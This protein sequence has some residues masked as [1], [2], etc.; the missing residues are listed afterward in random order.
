MIVTE[1]MAYHE[2]LWD[3]D[4]STKHVVRRTI[5]E[6]L[7]RT[8]LGGRGMAARLLAQEVG[9]GTAEDVLI[10]SSGTLTGTNAPMSGRCTF[11]FV[12]PATQ[13]YFKTSAGGQLGLY[14][15]L[16][17]VDYLLIRGIADAPLYIWVDQNGPQLRSAEELW[18]RC[19]RDTTS[20][21][22]NMHKVPLSAACIGP[23][24]E[25]DVLFASI[26][27]STYNAAGRGGGGAVMGR[28]RLKAIAFALPTGARSVHD[29]ER[30]RYARQSMADALLNDTMARSYY[31]YGTAASVGAMNEM[32]VLPSY[33]FRTG[34]VPDIEQL[35]SHYWNEKGLLKGRIGCA[36]CLYSCHRYVQ[37][38]DG[39]YAG[40]H[41]AGPEY[42]T[43]SALGSGTGVTLIGAVHRAN[44]LCNDLGMDTIS[45]GG[46][47][48]WAMESH[49]R[50]VLDPALVNG[51]PLVF[52]NEDAIVRLPSMIAY[53]EGIGDL[54]ADGV[55]R[56][57]KHVG[58]DSW[59]WAVHTRGL[60][61]SR[62]ETR[63]TMSYA[64]AFAIN[65][66]GP[67]HLHS[68]CLAE[69]G[70]TPEAVHLIEQITGDAK[71]ARPDVLTK[72]ADIVRWHE[73]IYAISDALGLCAFITT[74]AYGATP[75]RCAELLVAATG[76]DL[77]SHQLMKVGKRI[78]T[79]ERLINLR[80]G[81]REDPASYA[82]WRLM[83]E[84]PDHEDLGGRM[85]DRSMLGELVQEYYRLHGWDEV[86]GI[87]SESALRELDLM[88]SAARMEGE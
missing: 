30:F 1:S 67:D 55:A 15:K 10:F 28:K 87:P 86:S 64:L 17:G 9:A 58:K 80:L 20:W 3:I 18:G 4:L 44:E 19:V 78:V 8:Y 88:S 43:V 35:T 85:L 73:D 65:P 46:A 5:P 37:I 60:E 32:G 47:I 45:V 71:L 72:R 63:G 38:D 12:S 40:T 69:F 23:A 70:M 62:V 51:L 81:W 75:A 6:K 79:L 42:E 52:G 39:L 61:Q 83:N 25:N 41:S 26:M 36:S 66:R 7:I 54:L 13:L 76:I 27:C 11:T 53:R 14:S 59:K 56:A 57:A 68:E 48:Q 31:D 82:P 29:P 21:L 49:E 33:N 84:K 24:G 77:D 34:S 16:S 2:I 50:G 22:E 74:A